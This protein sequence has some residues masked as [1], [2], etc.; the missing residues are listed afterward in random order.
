[1]FLKNAWY[2]ASWAKDLPAGAPIA[3]TLLGE[4][5]ASAPSARQLFAPNFL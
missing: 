5:A 2:A 1:M 3:K 4:P